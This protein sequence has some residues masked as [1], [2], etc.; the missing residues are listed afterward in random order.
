MPLRPLHAALLLIAAPAIAGPA[1]AVF[2]YKPAVELAVENP[3]ERPVISEGDIPYLQQLAERSCKCA[4]TKSD[5]AGKDQCWDGF[6]RR[7][8]AGPHEADLAGCYPIAPLVIS[9]GGNRSI[10]LSYSVLADPHAHG[11]AAL[12]SSA[13][14]ITAEAVYE[15]AMEDPR[16]KGD[17]RGQQRHAD[18]AAVN[19]AHSILRGESFKP[20]PP[21]GGCVSMEATRQD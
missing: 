14:A 17:L 2:S 4:R 6:K 11:A 15:S 7:T 20:A 16:F 3:G 18:A 1:W 19:F 12:C 5:M 21:A 10:F 9:V 8:G 13:E